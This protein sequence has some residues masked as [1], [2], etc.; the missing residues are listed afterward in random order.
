MGL[1]GGAALTMDGNGLITAA[2]AQAKAAAPNAPAA[3]SAVQKIE[4]G[5]G[6]LDEYYA[7]FSSGQ[8]GEIAFFG[9]PSMQS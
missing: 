4:V 5:P 3:R 7:F 2:D 6:E 9:L 1:A 8:T